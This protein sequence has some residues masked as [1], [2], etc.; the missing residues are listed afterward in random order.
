MIRESANLFKVVRKIG[1][2]RFDRWE[3]ETEEEARRFARGRF[4]D[5]K[6]SMIYGVTPE[7]RSVMLG[8]Q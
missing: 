8:N 1:P 5:D 4:G 6:R 7:G 3:F 2:G